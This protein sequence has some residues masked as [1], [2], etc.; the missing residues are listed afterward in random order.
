MQQ[1]V[2]KV[3]KEKY[4]EEIGLKPIYTLLVDGNSLMKVCMKDPKLNTKGEHVGGLF[5]FLLQLKKLMTTRDWD[6]VYCFF[7]DTYS[8][9]LRYKLYPYYKR[10]RDKHYEDYG[11]DETLSDY[12]KEYNA[13]LD[14]MT[15]YFKKKAYERDVAAGK[16]PTQEEIDDANFK[17]ERQRLFSYLNE[18]YIRWIMDSNGTE[19]DDLIAYYI[20]NRKPEEK[21]V[22]VSSD[23]DLSQL[24]CDDVYIYNPHLHKNITHKNF[25]REFGYDYRNVVTKKIL[26]GDDS[27]NISNIAGLSEKKLFETVPE[28]LD[29]AVTVD[30]VIERAKKLIEERIA[31]K[32]K[33]LKVHENIVNGVSNK[34]YNG[35]FYEINRKIIDLNEPLLTQEAKDEIDSMAYAVQDPSGRS[36]KHLY[37]LVLEDKIIDL[38]D[39]NHFSSFFSSF[40]PFISREVKR[41]QEFLKN[42]K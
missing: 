37:G 24:L 14:S 18:L 1:P 3:V 2:R 22:I 12:M 26:C 13:R 11:K 39:E 32:K 36:F 25:K 15:R 5:Q 27:D 21:I 41:Y 33:P 4:G 20:K 35:D 9:I 8:G 10:N 16:E 28:M 19:A 17:R 6:Y 42:Q 40:N 31:S 23:M 34:D 29:R 30:E 38:M 7:D